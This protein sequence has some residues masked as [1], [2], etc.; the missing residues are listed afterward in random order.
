M[1]I[2]NL[3]HSQKLGDK[4]ARFY[5]ACVVTV[6]QYLHN[7]DLVY[8]ALNPENIVIGADG[9]IKLVDFQQV[10]GLVER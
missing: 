4:A 6:L 10:A 2:V 7:R 1:V 8:R 9:Y 3:A 5:A